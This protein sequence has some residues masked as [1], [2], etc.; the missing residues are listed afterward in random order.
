[1]TCERQGE[2]SEKRFVYL[3]AERT[4]ASLNP[5]SLQVKYDG[6]TVL[7]L[8]KVYVGDVFVAAGQSNMELNYV[9]YYEGNNDTYNFGNGLIKT[10]DL[11]KPLVDKN[12]KFV[13]ADHDVEDTDFP[14]ANVNQN[15]DAWLNA[16]STNSL[17]L[18]YSGTAIRPSVAREAS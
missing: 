13:I 14:L 2:N 3:H 5:Y 9:Q 17:H 6:K 11:P 16:D 8:A 1:M 10:G 18:S 12:V 7:K 4:K 15:A